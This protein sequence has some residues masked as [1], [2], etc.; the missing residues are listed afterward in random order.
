MTRAHATATLLSVGDELTLG[1][2]IDTNSAWLA[3]Q[4]EARSVRT[5]EHATVDD[6]EGRIA[7]AIE[8]L[9]AAADLLI[10][11]GGLGP[12]ADDLTRFALARVL[13]DRSDLV[14]DARA[15]AAIEAWFAGRGSAM[16][17]GNRVQALRPA[18][19][20]MLANPNGTAPGLFA[21]VERLG[22]D[23]FCLP[24]PPREMQPMFAADV[25]PALRAEGGRVSGARLLLTFGIG[26]STVAER[27]G[28]LMDRDRPGRGLPL[29]GT[30]ASRCVVTC[31]LRHEAADRASL[32]A[33]LDE[34][35]RAVRAALGGAVFDRRDLL[36]G[37]AA[38]IGDALPGVVLALL[39]E[40]GARL[41]T[42]E[43]CT[44]GMIGELLTAVPGSSDAYAG[45]WVTYTN[46]MKSAQLG[47]PASVFETDGAVSGDCVRA[48]AAGALDRGSAL[49]P[50]VGYAVA[51]S[52]IA[53]PGGG[54]DEKPVGTV[55]I[56]VASAGGSVDARRFVFRGGRAAVREWSAMA[57]L[58]MV[59]LALVGTDMR[60]LGEAE[61]VTA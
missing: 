25:F 11:T 20:Q 32:V 10:I 55:W 40:R 2:T 3:S 53:G 48:M 28:S 41:V 46:A 6:D 12:T 61:R 51:V 33:G 27:L 59:R 22:C 17:A 49:D 47:V 31:R 56:A 14:E 52:G 13:G 23:V 45:G 18:A 39:R 1:Q 36:S 58:G 44:G 9:A 30:T 5:I 43:S 21:R 26:E 19:A 16:P 60:L 15:V 8:R 54:S 50:S 57:A 24:G 34:A 38:E 29:V 4:L 7:A 42:A 35:E 37:D